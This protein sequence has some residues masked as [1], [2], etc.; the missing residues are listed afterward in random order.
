MKK[1]SDLSLRTHSTELWSPL[2]NVT[3]HILYPYDISYTLPFPI[4]CVRTEP[5]LQ[6]TVAN[7]SMTQLFASNAIRTHLC[8]Q[9][10]F[11]IFHTYALSIICHFRNWNKKLVGVGRIYSLCVGPLGGETEHGYSWCLS[12]EEGKL[13]PGK[14]RKRGERWLGKARTRRLGH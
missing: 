7:K 2:G 3:S 10:P 11:L 4:S 14:I 13:V 9:F 12:P 8:S 6:P 1:G 5:G